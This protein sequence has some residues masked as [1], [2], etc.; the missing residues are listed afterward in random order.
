M[1]FI[2][3][4]AFTLS[5]ITSMDPS[6]GV[7]A[8]TEEVL[9]KTHERAAQMVSTFLSS[10]LPQLLKAAEGHTVQHVVFWHSGLP[11]DLRDELR[12]ELSGFSDF[13]FMECDSLIDAVPTASSDFSRSIHSPETSIFARYWLK[14]NDV[15][16]LEFFNTIAK[17]GSAE[18][19]GMNL[20]LFG[21]LDGHVINSGITVIR[22]QRAAG[23][24]TELVEI[25]ECPA[26]GLTAILPLPA[27]QKSKSN[28][29]TIVDGSN[30]TKLTLH[31]GRT[32]GLWREPNQ[33]RDLDGGMEPAE[34]DAVR[35]NF[36]ITGDLICFSTSARLE[37]FTVSERVVQA[38]FPSPVRGFTL[39]ISLSA[40]EGVKNGHFYVSYQLSDYNGVP[41][42]PDTELA[43]IGR[44]GNPEIAHCFVPEVAAGESRTIKHIR[45][46]A[47]VLCSGVQFIRRDTDTP[48]I[49]VTSAT[50]LFDLRN[51]G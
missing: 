31:P 21:A 39:D 18:Y 40:D 13:S 27:P 11:E 26:Q 4:T 49:E 9:T 2:G 5:D 28:V 29:P 41:I 15:V 17:Y 8:P 43:G 36:P 25:R 30:L 46:P 42:P 44:V 19:A 32:V 50:M 38:D 12:S 7:P 37:P 23:T 24:Q 51:E 6:S 20:Q 22:P 48:R 34:Q 1:E 47:G 3:S 14:P 33:E 45:P 16:S 10:S 35:E